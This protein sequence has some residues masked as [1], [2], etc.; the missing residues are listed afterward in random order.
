MGVQSVDE[1]R[2]ARLLVR[3]EFNKPT[4]AVERGVPQVL[5]DH[6]IR[7]K[8]SSSGRLELAKWMTD[9][10]NPLTARVMV[11]RIWMHLLGNGIVRSPENFGATGTAP[12]HPELLDYLALEFMDNGWS[13]KKLIREIVLSRIYRT[14]SHFNPEAFAVDP[15]NTLFWRIDPKRLE[16]EAIRDAM[17][18]VSGELDRQ[19]PRASVVGKAGPGIVRNGTVEAGPPLAS[20][21]GAMRANGAGMMNDRD[22]MKSDRDD[23][24]SGNRGAMANRFNNPLGGYLRNRANNQLDQM[25]LY[26]S[27][28]L[29]IVRDEYP[30]ALEV[31]DFA[32]ANLVVGKARHFKHRRSRLVL[33]QRRV[34]DRTERR[35]GS[36]IDG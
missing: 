7:I 23:R 31:L 6:P 18:A 9:E 33:S 27:V 25:S 14:S 11:N 34:R 12:T 32:D 24:A 4:D 20:V 8:E 29:P 17:L 26:R 5:T 2:N 16:A 22:S 28:Y 21:L 10:K 19:R 36:T 35:Y 1:P 3:G 30:R 15:E 13:V